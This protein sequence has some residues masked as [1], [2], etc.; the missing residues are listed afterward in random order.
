MKVSTKIVPSHEHLVRIGT[1]NE[2]A[3][4]VRVSAPTLE[5]IDTLAIEARETF[6]AI[7][8]AYHQAFKDIS[9]PKS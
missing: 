3:V 2:N 5:E 7:I 6:Q 9:S 8:L 4:Y 1:L